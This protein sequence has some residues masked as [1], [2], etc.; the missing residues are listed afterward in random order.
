ML[1]IMVLGGVVAEEFVDEIMCMET[2]CVCRDDIVLMGLN[3]RASL[4]E[5]TMHLTG[6][7]TRS[8]WNILLELLIHQNTFKECLMQFKELYAINKNC[9]D[10]K[11]N[12]QHEKLSLKLSNEKCSSRQKLIF[13]CNK[14]N[15]KSSSQNFKNYFISS[16]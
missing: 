1:S 10:T 13:H 8:R 16:I 9:H 6:H 3:K 7:Q 4:Y 5:Q 12:E 15:L 14:I 11:I 2:S